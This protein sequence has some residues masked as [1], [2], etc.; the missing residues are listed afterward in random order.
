MCKCIWKTAHF[1]A[2]YVEIYYLLLKIM[3]FYVFK[4]AANGGH[5]FEINI[6]TEI[7][8]LNLFL[9]S[10]QTFA[11]LTNVRL[12]FHATNNFVGLFYEYCSFIRHY[13]KKSISS[14]SSDVTTSLICWFP[15]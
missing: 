7:I 2:N 6:K 12:V 9:N 10:M 3:Q 8:K 13:W 11:H 1:D 5:H 4:M 14:V 15:A